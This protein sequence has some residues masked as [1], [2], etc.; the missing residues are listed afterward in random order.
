MQWDE[1]DFNRFRSVRSDAVVVV[2]MGQVV[3][4]AL[5]KCW[6]G[7]VEVR[8]VRFGA[9]HPHKSSSELDDEEA[10][11]ARRLRKNDS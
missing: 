3:F 2:D 7:E 6:R 5:E 1:A 10:R 4:G 11:I 9:G 8:R